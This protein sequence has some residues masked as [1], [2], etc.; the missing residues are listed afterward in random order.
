[1]RAALLAIAT[2]MP[3]RFAGVSP[4]LAAFRK[5]LGRDRVL[6]ALRE[7]AERHLGALPVPLGFCTR[8][9]A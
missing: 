8:A 3:E 5:V 9:R 2:L 4:T 7:L 6:E 1:M